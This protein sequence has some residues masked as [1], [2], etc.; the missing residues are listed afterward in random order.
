MPTRVRALAQVDLYDAGYEGYNSKGGHWH[1]S[2]MAQE[3]GFCTPS[4]VTIGG[5]NYPAV[6]ALDLASKRSSG[7]LE[8]GER[9]RGAVTA[10]PRPIVMRSVPV[11][12]DWSISSGSWELWPPTAAY[13]GR[14]IAQTDATPSA[15]ARI[16]SKYSL[17]P[18]PNFSIKLWC[19]DFPTD[20]PE[21]TDERISFTFGQGL[22]SIASDRKHTGYL[23]ENRAGT[24]YK[25]MTFRWDVAETESTLEFMVLRQQIVISTDYWESVSVYSTVTEEVWGAGCAA[26]YT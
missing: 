21:A 13:E 8:E 9:G 18:N 12:T 16:D 2:S 3:F 23:M 14:R 10:I 5:A 19:A 11:L 25:V 17:G 7:S 24:W 26:G 1:G 15:V 6:I 4:E 22:W 20:S